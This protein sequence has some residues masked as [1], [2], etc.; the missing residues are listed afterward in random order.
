MSVKYWFLDLELI[1]YINETLSE[2]CFVS[3]SKTLITTVKTAYKEPAYYE[4]PVTKEL[5]HNTFI[6]NPG[7]KEHMIMVPMCSLKAD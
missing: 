2:G 7:H 6:N 3:V 5:V 1:D 4:H